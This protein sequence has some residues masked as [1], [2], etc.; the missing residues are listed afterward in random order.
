MDN[1]IWAIIAVILSILIA[2]VSASVTTGEA[3]NQIIELQQTQDQNTK[4]I[5]AIQARTSAQDVKLGE[6]GKDV[7]YITKAV[8][9]IRIDVKDIQKNNNEGG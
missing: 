4:A 1:K 6:I 2:V 5:Q 8:D 3:K 9:E 7:L